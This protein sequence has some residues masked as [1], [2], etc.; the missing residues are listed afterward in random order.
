[1]DI[2]IIIIGA[3]AARQVTQVKQRKG[4]RNE[5]CRRL[6]Q[7]KGWRHFAYVT[8]HSLTFPP[9]HLRHS[10]FYN[11]SS[12]LP[13]SELILQSLRCFTYVIGTSPTSQLILQPSR[14]FI[15]ATAHSTIPPPLHVRQRSFYNP[16]VASPAPQELHVLHLAS[17][18]CSS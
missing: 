13:T 16:S 3:W 15:Y 6:K 18:P 8:A 4:C 12:A 1:M 2:L 7:C 14:R 9:L 5:L 17:C 10:S 11:P